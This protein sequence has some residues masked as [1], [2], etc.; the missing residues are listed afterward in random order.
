MKDIDCDLCCPE[1]H[2]G[3]AGKANAH[4]LCREHES[5]IYVHAL[6]LSRSGPMFG[7]GWEEAAMPRFWIE[8]G[9]PEMAEEHLHTGRI[10]PEG[11]EAFAHVWRTSVPRFSHFWADFELAPTD[12]VVIALVSLLRQVVPR[13]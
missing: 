9:T 13:G 8:Q 7:T 12:P 10:T 4:Y 2:E 11:F 1:S 5:A 6:A 3:C